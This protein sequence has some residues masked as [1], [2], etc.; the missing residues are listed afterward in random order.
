MKI[1]IDL[2]CPPEEARRAVGL[3][4]LTPLHNMFLTEMQKQM[5]QAMKTMD[6]DNIIRS[7]MPGGQ[8]WDQMQKFWSGLATAGTTG[9]VKKDG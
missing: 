9:G 1:S 6:G 4:D 3:P 8:G 2:D 5:A 7:W